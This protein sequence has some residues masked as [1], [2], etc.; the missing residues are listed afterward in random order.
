M[1][2]I[3]TKPF[4]GNMDKELERVSKEAQHNGLYQVGNHQNGCE[5]CGHSLDGGWPTGVSCSRKWFADGYY[6]VVPANFKCSSWKSK[7]F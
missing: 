5:G 2:S 1:P 4:F 6:M 3:K 7:Y